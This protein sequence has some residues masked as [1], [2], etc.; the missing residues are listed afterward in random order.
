ML[1]IA[2][3]TRQ[4]AAMFSL[5]ARVLVRFGLTLCAAIFIVGCASTQVPQERRKPLVVA[6]GKHHAALTPHFREVFRGKLEELLYGEDGAFVRAKQGTV[7]RWEA[8]RVDPGSRALRYMVG[9]GA[10][11]GTFNARAELLDPRGRSLA[12]QTVEGDQVMGI[13]GGSYESAIEEAA[14]NV[15][16]FARKN[17]GVVLS[18]AR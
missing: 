16:A 9:F 3:L 4:T 5:H 7:L 8:V 14:E 6:E 12:S 13:A 15:A 2:G 18:G 10:G 11:K 1:A 17:A